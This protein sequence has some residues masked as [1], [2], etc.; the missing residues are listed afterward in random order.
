MQRRVVLAGVVLLLG[1][2]LLVARDRSGGPADGGSRP[3]VQPPSYGGSRPCAGELVPMDLAAL[4]RGAESVVVARVTGQRCVWNEE[5][6]FIWT[7]TRLAVSECWKGDAG[8]EVV[9]RE[10]GGEIPPVAVLVP[11]AARYRRGEDVVVFLGRDALGQVRT[12][13]V[14]QGRLRLVPAALGGLVV[15][16]S[17]APPGVLDGHAPGRRPVPLRKL[18]DLVSRLAGGEGR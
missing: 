16:P 10:P 13:G 7:E 2:G 15:N 11:V 8:R 12:L 4:C 6:T 1:L 5:R 9:V 17:A 14:T 3:D 18:R